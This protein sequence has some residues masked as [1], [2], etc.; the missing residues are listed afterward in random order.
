MRIPLPIAA[1]IVLAGCRSEAYDPARAIHGQFSGERAMG[2]VEAIVALGPK[3]PGSEAIEETRVY[4]GEVLAAAGWE[5]ER[6]TFD[7]KTPQGTITF[8]NLR[9]RFPGGDTWK[10]PLDGLLCSHFDTKFYSAFEFVGANDGGSSTGLL[11]EMA[12]VLAARPEL[13]QK[14][15]LVFFDGEEAYIQ[16]TATDGLYGSRFYAKELRAWPTE[17]LPGWAIV[18]DMVGDR[19]LNIRIPSNSDSRL[20]GFA[21]QAADDLGVRSKFGL[22]GSAIIDD[23][24]PLANA[25]IPAID[26]IDLDYRPWHTPGDT[27]DKLSAESLE[28]V[29]QTGLLMVEKY[30]LGGE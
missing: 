23:H 10:R 19:D 12:R 7:D 4:L 26:I 28:T 14:L 25:G 6:Q 16:F 3:P 9:A 18:F 2:H 21:L 15:E 22:K 30:L 1:A 24:V 27:L 29:G 11:L 17:R 5:V 13:A 8:A 20:A